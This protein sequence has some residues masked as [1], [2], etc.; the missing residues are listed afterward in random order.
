MRNSSPAHIRHY[1]AKVCGGSAMVCL[2]NY[3]EVIIFAR[4][5]EK[6]EN[7]SFV[8]AKHLFWAVVAEI[9]LNT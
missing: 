8:N 4:N 6:Q 7:S 1:L 2:R 5:F 3:D 9:C